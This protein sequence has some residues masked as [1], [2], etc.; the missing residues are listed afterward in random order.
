SSGADKISI[1]SSALE[2]PYLITQIA[3]RFGTQCVV[4]GIDSWFNKNKK[5][6]IVHQYTGDI[7]KTIETQWKTCDW[8]KKVQKN[9]AGEI[10]LNMMNQDGLQLGYDIKQL[11]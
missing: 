6:Y 11:C 7:N 3:E 1:N 5:S 2:N 8:I 9:G 4:V 10:V